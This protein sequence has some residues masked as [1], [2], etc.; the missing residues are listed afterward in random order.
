MR[1][2]AALLH[3]VALL[4]LGACSSSSANHAVGNPPADAGDAGGFQHDIVF[5]MSLTVPAYTELHKCQYVQLPANGDVNVTGFAHEYTSGSHHFL[6][7][8]TTLTSIPSGMT[9]QYDCTNGNEPIWQ[10]STGI[11]Y[12]AQTPSGEYA[13]PAGV[14]A[15]LPSG[16]VLIMNTHY[17]NAT[18]SPIVSTVQMGLDTTTPDK[19]QTQGGFFIF[20]DPFIDVPPMATGHSG[21][22]CSVPQD[23]TVLTAFT[24]YHYRGTGM[25]VWLD[26][27]ATAKAATPFYTTN[28]WQHPTEF[29]GPMTWPAASE[30]RFQCDYD[31]TETT[32]VF[33]GPN[34][35]TSEMCVLAGLYYPRPATQPDAFELCDHYS[36][37]GFGSSACLGTA[38]CLQ[39]CPASD[40]PVHTSA[41]AVVGPCWEKCVAAACAGAVDTVFPLFGCVS[42][43]C[44]AECSGGATTCQACATSKCAAQF[45]ACASQT[46]P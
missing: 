15:R 23:L 44:S 29:M 14:A 3:A 1:H 2:F 26:P 39:A 13:F 37:S 30:V 12:G 46:C 28:D 43:Q 40:A 22:R 18:G 35:K 38:Q 16:G 6:L 45:S 31:N 17:L 24:H 5:T 33:Q 27:S 7:Y 4:A 8:R 34:A 32:E 25:Q 20:Y 36:V 19:V 21:G 9:G 10:Y 42:S 11:A 41:G